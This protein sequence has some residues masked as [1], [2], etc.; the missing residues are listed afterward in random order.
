MGQF[1]PHQMKKCSVLIQRIRYIEDAI[2]EG[3]RSI[4][5]GKRANGKHTK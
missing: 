5:V 2:E 4:D 3:C 1:G